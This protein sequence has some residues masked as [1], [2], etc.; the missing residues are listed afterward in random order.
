MRVIY[1][2]AVEQQARWRAPLV[3]RIAFLGLE[4]TAG[5]RSR[6]GYPP[7]DRIRRGFHYRRGSHR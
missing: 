5:G 1:K 2:G 6:K 7:G 4:G 3:G